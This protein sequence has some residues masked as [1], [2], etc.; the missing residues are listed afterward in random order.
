VARGEGL[1]L[2]ELFRRLAAHLGVAAAPAVDP[3][4]LRSADIM[5][6]VG[7]AA[8]LRAATG[9]QPTIGLDRIVKEVADAE[10]D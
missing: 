9:W 8:K 2:R 1:A 3:A 7:D 5:H 4:L 10:A 6:L